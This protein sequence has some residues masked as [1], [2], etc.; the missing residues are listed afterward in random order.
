MGT[1]RLNVDQYH[2]DKSGHLADGFIY[3]F[4]AYNET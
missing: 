3:L 2:Y 1:T 4:F